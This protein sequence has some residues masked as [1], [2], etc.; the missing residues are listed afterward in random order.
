VIVDSERDYWLFKDVS[1]LFHAPKSLEKFYKALGCQ[2][3][4]NLIREQY[5]PVGG[6]NE[7]HPQRHQI[8]GL[9]LERLWIF[10]QAQDNPEREERYQWMKEGNFQ[11]RVFEKV[12]M[13]KVLCFG[14]K[15]EE[16]SCETTAGYDYS[17][18]SFDLLV[19]TDRLDYFE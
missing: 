14:K 12:Q 2:P 9:V 5:K 11:V 15:E 3:L 18:A 1:R 13:M 8:Q 16:R 7:N 4:S 17:E 10:L 19:A 6:E